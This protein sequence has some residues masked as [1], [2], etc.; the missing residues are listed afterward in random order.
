MDCVHV[1]SPH[2]LNCGPIGLTQLTGRPAHAHPGQAR[3]S[4]EANVPHLC[5]GDLTG[6]VTRAWV[7]P[8]FPTRAGTDPVICLDHADP[9]GHAHSTDPCLSWPARI[10]GSDRA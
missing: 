10:S 3:R 2:Q 7:T 6:R 8:R 4:T 5:S 1:A 9:W